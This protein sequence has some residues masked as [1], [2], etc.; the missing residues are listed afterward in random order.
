MLDAVRADIDDAAPAGGQHRRQAAPGGAIGARQIDVQH[1]RPG[2]V[3]SLG[4]QLL[5]AD[6]GR[7]HQY[8]DGPERLHGGTVKRL[9]G[10]IAAQIEGREKAAR[11]H[12]LDLRLGL[13]H[14]LLRGP[15]GIG[16]ADT[17]GFRKGADGDIGS[18]LRQRQGDSASDARGAARD[19][20]GTSG[21]KLLRPLLHCRDGDPHRLSPSPRPSLG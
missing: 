8:A 7:V 20:G 19:P 5:G 17:G 4:H 12:S 6:P 18:R 9:Y 11:A 3:P 1:R 21:E 13:A 15:G 10:F 2:V 16:D 14:L